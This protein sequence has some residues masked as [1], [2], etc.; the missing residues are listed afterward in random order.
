MTTKEY[1][2]QYREDVPEWLR[3]FQ[4][5]ESRTLAGFL[6]SR[7]VYYPGSGIDGDPVEVFGASHSVHCFVYA[8]YWLSKEALQEGLHAHGWVYDKKVTWA[9]EV[10]HAAVRAA[11]LSV[12]RSRQ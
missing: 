8:D 3:K 10:A 12:E 5:G 11:A 2:E 4:P 6:R 7:I 9:G 1:L